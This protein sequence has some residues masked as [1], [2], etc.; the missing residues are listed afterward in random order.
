MAYAID[1]LI[2]EQD[3]QFLIMLKAQQQM[4]KKD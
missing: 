1:Y 2:K 4:C 3:K